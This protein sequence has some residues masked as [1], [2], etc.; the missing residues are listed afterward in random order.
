MRQIHD[1]PRTAKDQLAPSDDDVSFGRELAK[2]RIVRQSMRSDDD[3]T[4]TKASVSSGSE[5]APRKL[6]VEGVGLD[7]ERSIDVNR[8]EVSS[9]RSGCRGDDRTDPE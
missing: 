5:A 9:R 7:G 6:R 4:A 3:V 2:D 1:G 8:T